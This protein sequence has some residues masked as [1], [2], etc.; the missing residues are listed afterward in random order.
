MQFQKIAKPLNTTHTYMY[1]GTQIFNEAR[2][3]LLA[4]CHLLK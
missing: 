2:E 3:V 1:N 4:T